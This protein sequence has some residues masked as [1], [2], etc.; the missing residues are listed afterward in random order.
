MKRTRETPTRRPLKLG[1]ALL[2]PTYGPDGLPRKRIPGRP[3]RPD[4]GRPQR[5]TPTPTTPPTPLRR[6]FLCIQFGT[7]LAVDYAVGVKGLRGIKVWGTVFAGKAHPAKRIASNRTDNILDA[8]LNRN[9][10]WP[11]AELLLGCQAVGAEGLLR[12]GEPL[13]FRQLPGPDALIL[14]R[15]PGIACRADA[16]VRIA[17]GA[18][19]P[20]GARLSDAF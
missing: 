7:F 6:G 20:T 12:R 4:P 3:P 13:L 11:S 8:G 17:V 14:A 9:P 10:W 15:T 5:L 18:R 1:F 2:I 19:Y 16:A